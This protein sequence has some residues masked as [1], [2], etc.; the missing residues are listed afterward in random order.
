MSDLISR[1]IYKSKLLK[2]LDVL[3]K[4]YR[5]AILNEDNDLILAI[6]NQQ[7]AYTIALRL[8]DNEPI[9]YDV[10][11]VVEELEKESFTTTDTVCG[12]IFKAIRL[13]SVIEIVK[14]EAEQY[15]SSEIGFISKTEVLTLIEE[16]KCNDDIPKNYGTLLDI[17]R[18]IR[19]M[20]TVDNTD[21]G[22]I[23][24][25]ERLPEE[26]GTYIVNAIENSIIHVTFAKWMPRMKKWNLTGCRSYWKVNAWQPLPEPFKERD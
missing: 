8:L 5:E 18:M 9:A 7:S 23:A 17:M 13:S 3:N 2:A 26:S 11:K 22:W 24:C 19:N 21:N 6:Q 15:Q 14:Q 1:S 10:N 12:G 25:S 4:E 16:I 20:P